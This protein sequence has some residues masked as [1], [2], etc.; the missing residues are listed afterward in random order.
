MSEITTDISHS[1]KE[2]KKKQQKPDINNTC[3][4]SKI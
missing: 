3:F 4:F 2:K 1:A